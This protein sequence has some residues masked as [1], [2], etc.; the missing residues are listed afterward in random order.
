MLISII[1]PIYNVENYLERC[2]CN[3]IGQTYGKIEIILVDDGSTDKS[4]EICDKYEEID[5]RIR[6]IHKINGGLSDARN[7][8]ISYATGDYIIF[9]DSDDYIELS[10]CKNLVDV[11]YDIGKV[12]VISYKAEVQNSKNESLKIINNINGFKKTI[13]GVNYLRKI[14]QNGYVSIEAWIYCYKRTFL[15]KNALC[16][17]KDLLHEDFEFTLR[18]LV[19]AKSVI[20]LNKV[21]YHYIIR[22]NS[23]STAKNLEKNAL[24]IYET[25]IK[26][27]NTFKNLDKE[28]YSM[29]MDQCVVTYLSIFVQGKMHLKKNTKFIDKRFVLRNAK[30]SKTRIKA[31][32]FCLS[33]HIYYR[34]H[35]I[36]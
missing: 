8:G 4:S 27:E 22:E 14:L 9:V 13:S 25:C 20:H 28:L 30:K 3:L 21:G 36:L 35:E 2:V 34:L 15:I 19:L 33:P 23:I 17:Q 6:V 29:L 12:E 5:S 10:L 32:L 31:F 18:A 11:I 24:H 7:V 16:F 1:V 26:H